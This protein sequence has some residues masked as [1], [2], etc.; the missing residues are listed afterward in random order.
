[1]CL[2]V[3]GEEFTFILWAKYHFIWSNN[4]NNLQWLMK[5]DFVLLLLSFY[6]CLFTFFLTERWAL[7]WCLYRASIRRFIGLFQH[8]NW[9]LREIAGLALKRKNL[10]LKSSTFSLTMCRY[11]KQ[12]FTISWRVACW[13]PCVWVV[14]S[15]WVCQTKTTFTPVFSCW[16]W[17]HDFVTINFKCL[18]FLLFH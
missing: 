2:T 8:N 16:M 14:S 11:G 15:Q 18:Y 12:Q 7:I 6:F 4:L 1:M 13:R 5:L 9:K 10:H 3:N 17:Y